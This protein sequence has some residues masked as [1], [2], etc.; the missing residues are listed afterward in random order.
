[1]I[2]RSLLLCLLFFTL[3]SFT[4]RAGT[5]ADSTVFETALDSADALRRDGQ[6]SDALAVYYELLEKTESGKSGSEENGRR[7]ARIYRS[8]SWTYLFL[9]DQLS[10]TYAVK[11]IRAARQSRDPG[12]IEKSYSLR[13]YT[14][15]EMPG[16]AGELNQLADSCIYYSRL[17]KDEKMLGEAYMHKCNALVELQRTEEAR[18]FCS[19]AE[20]VYRKLDDEN[21]LASALSNIGNV[22]LKGGY[23]Q[24]ALDYHLRAYALSLRIGN[25]DFVTDNL[26]NLANDYYRL[27]RYRLSAEHYRAYSDSLLGQFRQRLD[28]KFAEAEARYAG[29]V[30]DREI[31][32]RELEI[33]RQ[34]ASRNKLLYGGLL[35]IFLLG[36]GSLGYIGLQRKKKKGAEKALLKEQE[37]NKLRADF[38]E[39]VAHEIRTPVT[40][41]DGYLKL[42][43]KEPGVPFSVRDRIEHALENNSRILK[44]AEEIME[45]LRLDTGRLP[46]QKADTAANRFC[47]RVFFSFRSLAE[48][49]YIKLSYRSDLPDLLHFECDLKRLE[50]IMNILLSNALKYA[51]SGSEIIWE[52]RCREGALILRLQDSGP[53]IAEEEQE[54]IFERFYQS[55]RIKHGGGVGIGLALARELCESMQ[56]EISVKSESGMG[57]LFTLRIPVAWHMAEDPDIEEKKPGREAAEAGAMAP[58]RPAIKAKPALL[59]VEDHPEMA[60]YLREILSDFFDCDLAFNGEEG[61]RALER[62]DYEI[63]ISDI[64]MPGMDGFEFKKKVNEHPKYK[65]TPFIFISAKKQTKDKVAAYELGVDDYI[66]KPFSQEEMTAR[67]LNLRDRKK[68]REAWSKKHPAPDEDRRSVEEKLLLRVYE[69]IAQHMGNEDFRVADLAR[70]LAYSPRQLSRLLRKHIGLSPVQYILELRLQLAYYCLKEK[71]FATLSELRQHVGI[72]SPSYFNSKFRERFGVRPSEL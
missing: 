11:A 24:K 18:V 53:G 60:S 47:R 13:Y 28:K 52:T 3:S 45:L 69:V 64:M 22:F 41:I 1:M 50:K 48:V 29:A 55:D 9:E 67:V 58:E 17:L 70:E 27:G 42:A 32:L 4:G 39:N 62:S 43:L 51:P 30:K 5:L 65:N 10:R 7:L 44:D 59:I 40:L 63:F 14:L 46:L 49:K 21:Y 6:Y 68:V 15:Y 56:G 31:A 12:E 33:A 72:S 37:M 66:I 16:A 71:R 61:L 35:L 34:A 23:L 8:I 36:S 19:K 2:A 26:A 20:E 25:R 38:L 57:A 54:K